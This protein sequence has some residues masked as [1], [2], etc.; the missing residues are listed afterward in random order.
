MPFGIANGKSQNPKYEIWD[1]QFEIPSASEDWPI[2]FAPEG[3]RLDRG[4]L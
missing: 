3:S 1:L 4:L 2:A